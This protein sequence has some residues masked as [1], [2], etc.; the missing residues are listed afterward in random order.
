MILIEVVTVTSNASEIWGLNYC[1]GI[2]KIK[3]QRWLEMTESSPE[4]S[5]VGSTISIVIAEN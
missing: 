2:L 1:N 5:D 4:A 3:G